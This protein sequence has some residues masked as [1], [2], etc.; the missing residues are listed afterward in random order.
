MKSIKATS[1]RQAFARRVALHR[2]N[3]RK[4]F[5]VLSLDEYSLSFWKEHFDT[6]NS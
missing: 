3:A 2:L 5:V 6:C 1:W 4:K